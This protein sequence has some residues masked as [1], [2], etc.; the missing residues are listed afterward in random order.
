M[1]DA[2]ISIKPG[3]AEN[4]LSGKKTVEL[5]T[6]RIRLPVGSRLWFYSTLPVGNITLSAE[7]D[8]VE[9]L[10]PRDMW[11]EHGQS[12]CIS[13]QA[14]DTYTKERGFVAAIGLRKI[15]PMDRDMCLETM[16]QHERNFQPP[17]FISRLHPGRALYSALYASV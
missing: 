7:I 12:I 4:M 8:F 9:T 3:H 15:T 11:K 14:F 13:R 1:D 6:R 10:T 17:Q 2:I 16:R 5:R